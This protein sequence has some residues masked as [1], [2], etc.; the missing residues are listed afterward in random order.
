MDEVYRRAVNVNIKRAQAVAKIRAKARKFLGVEDHRLV[1]LQRAVVELDSV[2]ELRKLFGWQSEPILDDPMIYEFASLED[3]NQ[4]RL[5]DAECLG[6]IA[7]NANP[8]VCLEIGTAEGHS[9]ALIAVNAPQAEVF[10]INIPPEDVYAGEG[11]VLTTAA[12][13][14]QQIGS[15]YRERGLTNVVQILENSAR[16]KPD[17]GTIDIAFIDGCHDTDFVYNDT[18][19]ILEHAKPGSFLLWHDFN[20]ELID[21]KQW[22]YSVCLGVE[23]LF[24]DGLLDGAVLHVRNSWIGVYQVS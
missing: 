6:T 23:K 2:E 20:L 8:K 17:I 10:T 4:R 11:G 1:H 18:L 5:R 14:R 16:W 19:K 9:T 12:F 22:I 3:I 15:Y 21:K 24:A 13:A 7:R